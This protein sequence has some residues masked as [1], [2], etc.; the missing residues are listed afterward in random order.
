[1]IVLTENFNRENLFPFTH[2]R[3]TA[4]LFIGAMTIRQKWE[5]L[6]GDVVTIDDNEN[7]V[8]VPSNII[9][10]KISALLLSVL[11]RKYSAFSHHELS[12]G[13]FIRYCFISSRFIY[14][15]V[16]KTVSES[17]S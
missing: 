2:T 15:E 13:C 4:D 17:V 10:E 11:L 1:M 12:I 8:F 7:G 3:H 9:F 16:S 5:L 6:T 14:S